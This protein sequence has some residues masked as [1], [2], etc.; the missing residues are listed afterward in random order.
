[1]D[2]GK[3]RDGGLAPGLAY[4]GGDEEASENRAKER[5]RDVRQ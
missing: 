2:V 4:T 3:F 5:R 1:M